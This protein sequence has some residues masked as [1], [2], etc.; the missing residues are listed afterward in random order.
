[1]LDYASCVEVDSPGLVGKV[2]LW[3][4]MLR[5]GVDP[6]ALPRK[7]LTGQHVIRLR[8]VAVTSPHPALTYKFAKMIW[9]GEYDFPG[10][11]PRPGWKV[12]DIGANVGLFAMLAGSRGA[13]VAACEPHPE[14][15][16]YLARNTAR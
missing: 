12:V 16:N 6:L 3:S 11:V 14:L 10:F 15:A 9:G 5:A 2:R 1:V 13:H 4:R 8:G 7:K